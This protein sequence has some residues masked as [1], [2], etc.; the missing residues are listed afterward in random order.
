MIDSLQRAL[1][2]YLFNEFKREL[3]KLP[4]ATMLSREV[5]F[6]QFYTFLDH[7]INVFTFEVQFS[8]TST[9]EEDKTKMTASNKPSNT[10]N[11]NVS[12][13]KQYNV[14]KSKPPA[15]PPATTAALPL[16]PAPAANPW[17]AVSG[18]STN[19]DFRF[20]TPGKIAPKSV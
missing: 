7:V 8:M 2:G 16:P 12:T 19:R 9:L 5:V 10:A 11:G 15:A 6:N 14:M 13:R 4:D 1:P 17:G 20:Q 3:Q 18:D